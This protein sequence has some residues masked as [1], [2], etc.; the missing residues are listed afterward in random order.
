VTSSVATGEVTR[1]ELTAILV[2]RDG[3]ILEE[4]AGPGV[5]RAVDGPVRRYE[6]R[7]EVQD[8]GGDLVRVR[9]TVDLELAVPFVAWLFDAAVR[10]H[11]GRLGPPG[12]PPWWAPPA[13]PDARAAAALSILA[14]AAAIGGYLVALLT[15]TV[16]F[17]GREFGEGPA[18]QG[19][20]AVVV[21]FAGFAVLFAAVA[22]ADR[23][24]RRRLL[25][26]TL[27]GGSVITAL[28]ALAPS[29][30]WLGATQAVGRSLGLGALICVSI[31]A[32]EE[33]PSGSRA[34]GVSVLGLA[35]GLG[36]GLA[37]I[38]LSVADIAPWG[39][40]LL[41]VVPVTAL[42][43]VRTIARRLP[44]TRR[45]AAPHPHA[46]LPGRGARL[47]L[48]G[49]SAILANLMAAPAAFYANRYLLVDH[50]FSAAEISLFTVVTGTPG[51]IGVVVGGRLADTRG[52]RVVGA[53]AVVAGTVTTALFFLASG[54]ALWILP[55]IGSVIGAAALPAL[56]VYGPELFPTSLRGRAAGLLS[57]AGLAGS[58]IGILTTGFLAERAGGVGPV[59]ATLGIGPLLVA[60]LVM[61]A[62]PETAGRSLEDLNPEDRAA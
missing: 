14:V 25:V 50:G 2:P 10:R 30:T 17:A 5:Y 46:S 48:L 32:A 34:Y 49:A 44:E 7:V 8:G 55:V 24:G 9:Q 57:L 56:G 16:A 20:V 27:A 54:V 39:W 28:G 11:L 61:I 37:A 40:R 21:R 43:L 36:A 47:G 33:M 45:F 35:G 6:R 4:E 18:A 42:L 60:G 53:V 58:A 51:V 15:T 23:L 1:D 31:M 38:A 3:L 22:T 41:Y 59:I 29:L 19:V 13:R 52:R 26:W 62:Y 12:P